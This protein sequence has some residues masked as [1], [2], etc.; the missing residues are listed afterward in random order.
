MRLIRRSKKLKLGDAVL[1]SLPFEHLIKK[2]DSARLPFTMSDLDVNDKMNVT[3]AENICKPE[4]IEE[5]SKVPHTRELQLYLRLMRFPLDAYSFNNLND[6]ERIE[7]I[8]YA[9]FLARGWKS[10]SLANEFL[11]YP[12]YL[13][14]ELNA[15]SSLVLHKHC[16][17]IDRPDLFNPALINSQLC[18]SLFRHMR[19][20]SGQQ[21]TAVNFTEEDATYRI[22][23]I[24]AAVVLEHRLSKRGK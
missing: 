14:L 19:S 1:T 12:C 24:E 9:V 23:R 20:L 17:L 21:Q 2:K 16:R 3:A 7:K 6:V 15:H 18:E 8:W 22:R 13:S 5:I 4:T 10:H 11:S